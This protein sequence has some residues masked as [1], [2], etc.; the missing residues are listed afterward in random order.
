MLAI[1]LIQQIAI[2]EASCRIERACNV[3]EYIMKAV[4]ASHQTGNVQIDGA[5]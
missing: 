4:N 2:N 5:D 3:T 1:V